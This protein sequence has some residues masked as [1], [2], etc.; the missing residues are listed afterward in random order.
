M[1]LTVHITSPPVFT[2]HPQAPAPS[3]LCPFCLKP[4]KFRMTMINGQPSERLDYFVCPQCR[5]PFEYQH[6]TGTLHDLGISAR[7]YK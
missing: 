3:L 7:K 4:L 2:E 5:S 1:V 6:Q